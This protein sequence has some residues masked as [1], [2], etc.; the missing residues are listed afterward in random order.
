MKKFHQLTKPQ[1][2]QAIALAVIEMKDCI[3]EGMISFDKPITDELIREY[4]YFAAE[5]AWYSQPFDKVIEG[6]A[7]EI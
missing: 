5:D 1:Q 2:D 7:E 6:I 4:A 3:E